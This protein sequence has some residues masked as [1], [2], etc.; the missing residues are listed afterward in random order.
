MITITNAFSGCPE[1][2]NDIKSITQV[3]VFVE[4]FYDGGLANFNG[5]SW[6]LDRDQNG[7]SWWNVVAM[8]H[9]DRGTLSFLDGHAETLKWKDI[10]TIKLAKES[11]DSGDFN[12]PDNPDLEYMTRRY[13]VPLPRK[14]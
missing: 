6:Q 5:G 1:K 13:A 3:Y 14:K 9:C 11:R 8:W 2:I 4:E 12:Q 7:K 10:R